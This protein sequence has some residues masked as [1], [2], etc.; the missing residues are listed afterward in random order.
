MECKSL[1]KSI[2]IVGS[3]C[4][5]LTIWNVNLN[6]LI[7]SINYNDRFILTIWNVNPSALSCANNSAKVLY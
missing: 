4:F 1:Q 5:I 6:R 3:K 7:G 2:E